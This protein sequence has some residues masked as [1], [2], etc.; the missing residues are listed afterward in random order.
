MQHPFAIQKCQ[1]E[2][3]KE[4]ERVEKSSSVAVFQMA[5]STHCSDQLLSS[6][7]ALIIFPFDMLNNICIFTIRLYI[8]ASFLFLTLLSFGFMFCTAYFFLLLCVPALPLKSYL[9]SGLF[10]QLISFYAFLIRFH[11]FPP[12]LISAS[13]FIHTICAI[14][15]SFQLNFIQN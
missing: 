8:S 10:N 2:R 1:R 4:E 7:I 6:R 9:I 11:F 12:R 5:L 3:E 13:V 14:V 15:L